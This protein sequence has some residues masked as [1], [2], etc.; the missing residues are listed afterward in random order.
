MAEIKKVEA[1]RNELLQKSGNMLV[2]DVAVG[3]DFPLRVLAEIVDAALMTKEEIQE[4]ARRFADAGADF[5]DVGMVA[6]ESQPEKAAD[7]VSWVKEA[8]DLP[9]SIDTLNVEEIRAAVSAGAELVLSADAGNIEAIAPYVKDVAVVVI[10][11][12][13]RQGYIP[14]SAHER[15]NFL[16]KIILKAKAL[17]VQRCLAD[18]IVEPQEIL[19]SFIAFKEFHKRNPEVPLFFGISNVTELFDA[20][21]VGLNALL[22]RLSA[23]V[24]GGI[25]L[26]T[27]KSIKAKGTVAE[28]ATAANMMFLAKKRGSVPKDLGIDLLVLKDKRSFEETYDKQTSEAD[29]KVSVVAGEPTIATLDK[30]G[31]FKIAVDRRENLLVAVHFLPDDMTKPVH[32]VKGKSAEAVYQKI[33]MIG[34]VSQLDHAAYLGMELAKA[35]T[36]LK[37]GKNY[38]QDLSLFKK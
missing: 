15:V 19:D 28:E 22:T 27:E 6:G 2:A 37:S 24:G 7:M 30:L 32:V 9:V 21:S 12:N 17:G 23:E 1:Q 5:I 33:L 4:T 3:A 25:L 14:K 38:V 26:A 35:E 36:A 13:Q 16:E 29:A 20:D 31:A 10:P 18:L 8:V 34:L 11:T